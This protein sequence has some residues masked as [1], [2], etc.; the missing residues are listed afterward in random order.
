MSCVDNTIKIGDMV[1]RAYAF[2]IEEF[3]LVVD[4]K[5]WRETMVPPE[6]ESEENAYMDM[7][8]IEVFTILWPSGY[9]TSEMDVELYSFEYYCKVVIDQLRE[10]A[11]VP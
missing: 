8:D 4:V 10:A 7:S 5:S 9:I 1:I 6:G 2:D 11:G 3:G